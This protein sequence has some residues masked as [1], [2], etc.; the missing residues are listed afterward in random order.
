[1]EQ[2][3]VEKTK[4][5]NLNQGL[6]PPQACDLEQAILGAVMVVS[7]SVDVMLMVI[8]REDVFY[9]E[10]HRYIFS[11]IKD[12]F[13]NGNPIDVLTVSQKL[14]QMNKLDLVGSD[15]YLIQLTQMVASS[16][17]LDFH[18]RIVLQKFIGREIIKFNTQTTMLAYDD[19]TDI[20]ELMGKLQG[21]FDAI[22]N[23]TIT[24]Q[25]SN[26]FA[27]NIKDLGSRIEFLSTAAES[28]EL[29]GVHTGF[30]RVNK[31]TGGYLP[32]DLI[33]L[34][35][36]PGMGKTS[37]VLKTALENVKIDNPVGFVSLEMSAMQLT[38][39]VVS[40]DTDFHLSQLIKTGFEKPK[41]FES[42]TNHSHRMSK[43]NLFIDDSPETDVNSIVLKARFWKRKY[44]I[45]LLIVDYLQLMTNRSEKGNREQEISSISRRMKMLAKE[46]EIPIIVLSQLSRAV[47]S[48]PNKRPL[49]SDLRESGAI[50][51][52]ADIIQ[53]IYRAGYYKLDVEDELMLSEGSDTEFIF[54]KY[55]G[56]SVATTG[57]KWIGDKTKFTDPTDSNE[58][59]IEVPEV[60]TFIPIGNPDDAF[61]GPD[62][63]H[64]M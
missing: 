36:R 45:K 15:Y 38:A 43:Y 56:G 57:L 25:K 16:A 39:R 30:K 47:E 55:R 6:I 59:Y 46:L 34:A 17:H 4:I 1:M 8:Q 26:T 40:I 60:E 63:Q 42:F 28:N 52:D 29:V 33:I 48:R 27:Q 51:Q 5:V 24:G 58:N 14:K 10:S 35:A 18:C 64:F 23:I 21:E 7:G 9:K 22:S 53:F 41:Y 44:G 49:L 20:F 31:F 13:E 3:K 54:A 11:A 32:T 2:I 12:L 50:E 19:S 61:G 37:L 62:K